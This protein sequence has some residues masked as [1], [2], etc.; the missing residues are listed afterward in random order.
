MVRHSQGRRTQGYVL[1]V[2]L[3]VIAMTMA[4]GALLASSLQYRMWLLR[5]EAES[6]HL[7]ALTDAG[8]AMALARFSRHPF[9]DLDIEEEV[10]DGRVVVESMLGDQVMQ[11]EVEVTATW[12]VAG[13]A[14]R[15]VVQLSDHDPPR[16]VS[17]ERVPFRPAGAP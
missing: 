13:R 3:F 16:V 4:A 17:W 11:R 9:D 10:G 5:Q 14:V 6:V 8:L 15:A 7:S 1:V 2:A 12:G